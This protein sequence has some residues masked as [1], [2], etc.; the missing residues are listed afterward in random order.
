MRDQWWYKLHIELTINTLIF[1]YHENIL[2]NLFININNIIKGF[3][4]LTIQNNQYV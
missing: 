2:L 1:V 3:L 4:F